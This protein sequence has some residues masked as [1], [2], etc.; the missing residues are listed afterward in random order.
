MDKL[1]FLGKR[2]QEPGSQRAI[3]F[4]CGIFQIDNV[5]VDNLLGILTLFFGICAILTP[6]GYSK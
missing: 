5:K 2:L 1:Y 3:M 6:E 4:L